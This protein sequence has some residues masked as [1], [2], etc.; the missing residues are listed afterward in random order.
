MEKSP[1]KH[2]DV[3]VANAGIGESDPEMFLPK[4]NLGESS[5]SFLDSVVGSRLIS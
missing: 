3:V 2:I 4:A 5:M 1:G